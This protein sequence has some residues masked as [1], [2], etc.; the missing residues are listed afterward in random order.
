MVGAC[1]ALLR[2]I[3]EQGTRP[4][5]QLPVESYVHWALY[6]LPLPPPG[7]SLKL[8]TFDTDIVCQ[9]PGKA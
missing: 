9:R 8:N 5:A 3:Y 4:G 2:A 1:Q 7:R 6:E